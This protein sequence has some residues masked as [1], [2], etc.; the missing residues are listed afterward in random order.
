MPS[1]TSAAPSLSA[2]RIRRRAL[3]G[4]E[5]HGGALPGSDRADLAAP[6]G[7]PLGQLGSDV[8]R[9]E[10]ET[11]AARY[12]VL[13]LFFSRSQLGDGEGG[14]RRC[15]TWTGGGAPSIC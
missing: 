10:A 8:A 14:G 12:V 11:T 13:S 5:T 1:W 3:R 6:G 2:R 4:S 7:V 15:W 9:G